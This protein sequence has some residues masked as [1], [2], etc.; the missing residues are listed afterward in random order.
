M[1]VPKRKKADDKRALKHHDYYMTQE[2]VERIKKT[3]TRL[4]KDRP[5]M[6]LEVT[7][8]KEMGDL[9]ENAAYQEAKYRLRS[10]DSRIFNLNEKLSAAI[11]IEGGAGKDGRIQIGSTVV[12]E[13]SGKEK[14]FRILG[15]L[16]ADPMKG[17]IS[18]LSPI[19]VNLIGRK[20][21]EDI[22]IETPNGTVV[23]KIID[24]K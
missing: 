6:V 8:T 9:S 5:A 23:Y 15:E 2:A 14:T 19:G 24:V 22:E 7:R 13:V 21:G 17:Q 16:E 10:T 18:H 4:E 3:I 11:I 1:R 20:A 12:A